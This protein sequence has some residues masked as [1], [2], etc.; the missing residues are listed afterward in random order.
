MGRRPA[1]RRPTNTIFQRPALFPHLTVEANVAFGLRVERMPRTE[2]R[3]RVDDLLELVELVGL[4]TG[5]ARTSSRAASSSASRS[6]GRSSKR[7]AVL[8]L[9][10]PLRRSTCGCACRCRGAEAHPARVVDNA[11]STSR[12]TRRRRSR[13]PTASRSCTTAASSRSTPRRALRQ[14]ADALHRGL[15]R[16][17]EHLRRR[18]RTARSLRHRRPGAARLPGAGVA[19]LVRPERVARRRQARPRAGRNVFD[20]E[21]EGV[22]FHGAT[23]TTGSAGE[24]PGADRGRGR[25]TP[26]GR[27]PRATGSRSAGTPPTP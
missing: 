25:T 6:R 5:A 27:S 2:I 10:E 14:P 3:R 21:V 20:A 17:D 23:S 12:T 19:A 13:C 4:R 1:Y 22:V 7:P 8:L 11:S 15:R 26:P 18:P 16:R 24:R 9:D